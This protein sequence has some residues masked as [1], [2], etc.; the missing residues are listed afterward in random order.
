MVMD[1]QVTFD[2]A[3][4]VALADFWASA[5]GYRPGD[6]PE[7]FATWEEWAAKLEIVDEERDEGAWLDDPEQRRPRLHFQQV[8]EPKTV[9]NRLHLD[10]NASDG[11]TAPLERRKEQVDAEAARLVALGARRFAIYEAT[12]HYHIVMRDPEG[13]EF[14]LR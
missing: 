9:K 4:P 13:N 7:G 2:C 5:L 3:A 1:F 10:L 12:D 6:P 8:P 11:P 14:C